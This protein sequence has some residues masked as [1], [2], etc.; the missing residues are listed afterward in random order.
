M[1]E[2]EKVKDGDS[3]LH[4]KIVLKPVNPDFES[5]VLTGVEEVELRVIAEFVE[6]LFF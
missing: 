6:V 3:W 2:S 4:A 5:I 1:G